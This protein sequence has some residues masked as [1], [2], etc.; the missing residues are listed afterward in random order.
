MQDLL[1][2]QIMRIM[3]KETMM[4]MTML[5]FIADMSDLDLGREYVVVTGNSDKTA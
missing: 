1:W 2:H 3:R 4:A 5:A